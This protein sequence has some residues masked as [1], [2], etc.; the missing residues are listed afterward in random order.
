MGIKF[1]CPQGHKL[2]VKSFLSGKKGICPHCGAKVRIPQETD[3]QKDVSFADIPEIADIPEM[4]G[5]E[6]ETHAAFAEYAQTSS[7]PIPPSSTQPDEPL[8][9]EIVE[10][11]HEFIGKPLTNS[12]LTN[13]HSV[14][15]DDVARHGALASVLTSPALLEAPDA[16]WYVRAGSGGQF[17]PATSAIMQTWLSEGRVRADAMVWREGWETWAPAQQV[18]PST[19]IQRHLIAPTE[20]VT[21]WEEISPPPVPSRL[22]DANSLNPQDADS[23]NLPEN[24]YF[25]AA[26]TD[27]NETSGLSSARRI[28]HRKKKNNLSLLIVILLGFGILTLIPALLHVL[29]N[30]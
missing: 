11:E 7:E 23:K 5:N 13:D 20:P 4:I 14:S 8:V 21:A 18:F 28:S 24:T 30:S 3:Q 16:V 9:H 19:N 2:H 6:S 25:I 12:N 1:F 27:S 22:E 17:G 29:K 15:G 10:P 26:G